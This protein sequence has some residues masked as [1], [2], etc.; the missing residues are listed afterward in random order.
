MEKIV[1]QLSWEE[2]YKKSSGKNLK[3]VEP[4]NRLVAH[5]KNYFIISGYGAFSEGYFLIITKEFI[6][7][8]GLD[9][10]KNIDELK[11]L[12]SIIKKINFLKY[13]RNSVVFEHGMCACVGG[14]DRAHLHIMTLHEKTNEKSLR[15][16]I[17]QTL[18]NRK[19][20]IKF[21]E[22]EKH[23]LENIHD[24]NHFFEHS[25]NYKDK[26]I[27]IHGKILQV[28]DIQNLS[29]NNWPFNTLEHIKKGGHYV[30]FKS[31][32]NSSSFLTTHNFQTQF[33][34]EVVYLNELKHN[35]KLEKQM[36]KIVRKNPYSEPWKWQNC[37]FE[38]NIIRTIK[39]SRKYLNKLYKNESEKFKKFDIE[40]I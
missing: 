31:Q 7:S 28:N 34:R 14:L 2:F 36:S 23:K 1:D 24:I 18:Y 21:I 29:S 9:N 16:S 19:A 15:I 26:D 25:K 3:K 27:K 13:G 30:Y 20:G 17:D 8:Y 22:F 33:G 4:F 40:I 5:S 38:K 37:M 39:F 10:K 35:R 32:Y 11:F 12:I 6:P